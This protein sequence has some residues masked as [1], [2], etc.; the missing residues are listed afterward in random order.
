MDD[1]D[2][3][4]EVPDS[5]P[6]RSE[7]SE[8]LFHAGAEPTVR[9]S[10]RSRSGGTF[11]T[12]SR[13]NLGETTTTTVKKISTSA[14]HLPSKASVSLFGEEFDEMYAHAHTESDR[15]RGIITYSSKRTTKSARHPEE[16]SHSN[17]IPVKVSAAHLHA[18][19]TATTFPNKPA[20]GESLDFT[21]IYN[22]QKKLQAAQEL[23]DSSLSKHAVKPGKQT[24]M[25]DHTMPVYKI[26]SPT[27]SRL[28]HFSIFGDLH[29]KISYDNSSP[30]SSIKP[31]YPTQTAV[32]SP[33]TGH[34][35]A[36]H[37]ESLTTTNPSTAT[38]A[39]IT[40]SSERK[41]PVGNTV[42]ADAAAHHSEA[43]DSKKSSGSND[44]QAAGTGQRQDNYAS[45][46]A[47][48]AA[49]ALNPSPMMPTALNSEP[50]TPPGGLQ[51]I[52]DQLRSLTQSITTMSSAIIAVQ[53]DI[54]VLKSNPPGGKQKGE[55]AY[56]IEYLSFYTI[57]R[58]FII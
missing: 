40:G 58:S 8:S 6:T 39:K 55:F 24:G 50:N 5:E 32:S 20:P 13:D 51:C 38:P 34:P 19:P 27:R 21:M 49:T 56:I 10:S 47:R 9:R 14:Q 53:Q 43:R 44:R 35:A 11:S 28:L 52:A 48:S 1:A 29:K 4:S 12:S 46:S 15:D 42:T 30:F 18:T 16:H 23:R 7:I 26:I 2:F 37:D 41:S 25:D 3:E 36:Q 33:Q 57:M 17:N 31:L 45:P 22:A 54:A